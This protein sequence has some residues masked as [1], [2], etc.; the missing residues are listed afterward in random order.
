[1]DKMFMLVGLTT[2][3]TGL[4]SIGAAGLDLEVFFGHPTAQPIVKSLGR[5]GARIFYAVLGAVF[6][7]IGVFCTYRWL[8][9]LG[10]LGG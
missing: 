2:L 10:A 5:L 8:Q 4:M 1:M 6:V 7:L 3:V 9:L